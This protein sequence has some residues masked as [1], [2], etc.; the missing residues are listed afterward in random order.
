MIGEGA[1]ANVWAGEWQLSPVAI[2]KFRLD[3]YDDDE[4]DIELGDSS[5]I[6]RR[7]SRMVMKHFATNATTARYD[8]FLNEVRIMAQLR[9]PNLVLYMGACGRPGDPLCI[10]SELCAGGS[11]HD[12]IHM[13][14]TTRPAVRVALE[15]ALAVARGMHYLHA[16]S[17]PILHRDL[18]PR[19]V[20]LRR[21]P[22]EGVKLSAANVA[23]CDFGLCRILLSETPHDAASP[24]AAPVGTLA[25]MSPTV[26]KGGI[27]TSKDDVY[28]FAVLM[29][30]LFTAQ[31]PYRGKPVAQILL[32]VGQDGLRPPLSPD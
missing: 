13:R 26:V 6:S 2:K 15:T 12:W 4:L 14:G 28:S 18:K 22:S 9:H 5:R 17:P 16:S 24:M 3:E 32:G 20:L 21:T 29:W 25:Y 23:I 8:A 27:F 30:E 10:V 11:L 1:F 19:N 7:V 31:L